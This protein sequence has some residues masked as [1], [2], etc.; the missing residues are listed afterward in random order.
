LGILAAGI[1]VY[2]IQTDE[3]ELVITSESDEVE[4]VVKKSGKL[5]RIVDAKTD[6]AITLT[7]RSGTYELELKGDPEGLKLDLDNVSLRRG[8][9]RLAKIERVLPPTAD[10]EKVREV[11][12]FVGHG[13]G[14]QPVAFS[15]D[16]RQILTG[17]HGPANMY[18]DCDI[19]LWDV[20]TGK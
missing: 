14:I 18:A 16:G 5:V 17:A 20:S 13:E 1:A 8:E 19:Q 12:R 2:R 15:P 3:G 7:L 9:T 4:V 11:H 10:W 6:K